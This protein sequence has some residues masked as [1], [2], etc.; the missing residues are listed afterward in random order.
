VAAVFQVLD[1]VNIVL[2]GALRGAKDVR[3]AAVIGVAVV[4]TCV[5]LAAWGLGERLGLGALGGWLGF[6]GETTL[7]SAALSWRWRR[8]PFRRPE[9]APSPLAARRLARA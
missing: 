4:W 6:L 8:A 9:P 2:R 1:A 7:G 5:P 3:V